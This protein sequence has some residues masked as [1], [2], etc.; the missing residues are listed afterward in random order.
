MNGYQNYYVNQVNYQPYRQ[1]QATQQYNAYQYQINN[2]INPQVNNNIQQIYT[3]NN[4][5]QP[6]QL[7]N[8]YNNN[9]QQ[10]I[11]RVQQIPQMQRVQQIPQQIQPRQQIQQIPQKQQI[12]QRKQLQ[13]I[14]QLQPVPQI[15]QVQQVQRIQQVPQI[16]HQNNNGINDFDD[17]RE[18]QPAYKTTTYN[19]AKDN[20]NERTYTPNQ[21][22]VFYNT[23][24]NNRA[25]ARNMTPNRLPLKMSDEDVLNNRTLHKGNVN[26]NPILNADAKNAQNN[27][28]NIDVNNDV[29]KDIPIVPSNNKKKNLTQESATEKMRFSHTPKMPQSL[30]SKIINKESNNLSK[31]ETSDNTPTPRMSKKFSR[32]SS[33]K[34]SRNKSPPKVNE[35]GELVDNNNNE[36]IFDEE[37][38][39]RKSNITQSLDK[40]NIANSRASLKRSLTSEKS[41]NSLNYFRAHCEGSQAGRNQNGQIKTNQDNYLV[42]VKLNNIPG[43]N[44]WGVLDGHGTHGHYVSAFCRDF[45]TNELIKYT[46]NL[47][48][49]G[50]KNVDEIYQHLKKENFNFIKNLYNKCD[51]EMKKQNN[52]DYILSGTTCNIIY[53]FGKH[54][55]C[56]SVGDSRGILVYDND[57]NLLTS[58]IFN[59]SYDHKP[60]LPDEYQRIKNMGGTVRKLTDQFGNIIG[61][62]Y[63]VWKGNTN[64]PGLAMSRSLGDIEGKSCGVINVPQF[65]EYTINE[66]SKY[67]VVCSDG[68]WEFIS[69]EQV[70]AIGNPFFVKE[71]IAGHCQNLIINA[72]RM[73]ESQDIIRDD[74]TAVIVYF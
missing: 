45:I 13:Q 46:E 10:N 52:F 24:T 74:I 23:L 22:P 5:I 41:V 61:G 70:M 33:L 48:V 63:R 71:D 19:F 60:D 29:Q 21:N 55:L 64:Y 47:K 31:T 66:S 67:M 9:I 49:S 25:A 16:Y 4:N 56:A 8:Q 44:L 20:V 12:P 62:P 17:I 69:N 3:T 73:W 65:I 2:Q 1:N 7:N 28:K 53:Q 39:D 37:G 26:K 27:M 11:H 50:I 43:F 30:Q 38:E 6:Y 34:M 58:N 68:V 51:E 35:K 15:Q 32:K 14:H 42:R 54:L 18:Y 40:K 72:T 57:K 36:F 59:L